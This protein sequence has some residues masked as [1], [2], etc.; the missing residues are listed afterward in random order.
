MLEE[1]CRPPVHVVAVV[2]DVKGSEKN[3]YKREV[4]HTSSECSAGVAQVEGNRCILKRHYVAYVM[5]MKKIT[6]KRG[7]CIEDYYTRAALITI[8]MNVQ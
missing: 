7:W 2:V 5:F 8:S 4:G 6:R 3:I 1:V